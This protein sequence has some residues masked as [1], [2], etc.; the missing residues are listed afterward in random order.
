MVDKYIKQRHKKIKKEKKMKKIEMN[1][2]FSKALDVLLNTKE[3]VLLR[4]KQ[5]PEKQ[6]F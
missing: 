1:Q 6:H 2:D 5:E 3:N 4:E